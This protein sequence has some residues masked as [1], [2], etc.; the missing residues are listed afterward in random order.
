MS[1]DGVGF[2]LQQLSELRRSVEQNAKDIQSTQHGIAE[3]RSSLDSLR[4]SLLWLGRSLLIA[5]ALTVI[6]YPKEVIGVISKIGSILLD[7]VTG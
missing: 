3:L 7:K 4:H 5:L 1:F 2:V 6:A